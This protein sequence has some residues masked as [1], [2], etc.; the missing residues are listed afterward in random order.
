MGRVINT[1]DPGK[2]RNH[3]MRTIAEMIRLLGQKQVVDGE[4]KDMIATIILSLEVVYQTVEESVQ[5]WEKRNYWKKA[6]DFQEKWY[7]VL[8]ITSQLKQLLKDEKWENLPTLI[9]KLFPHFSDIEIN[10][11]MRSEEDW[12]GN[13]TRLLEKN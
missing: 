11:M 2:R 8:G 9:M 1:N 4:A 5:A 10:K 7:W 12:V 6:D 13:Y 3:E